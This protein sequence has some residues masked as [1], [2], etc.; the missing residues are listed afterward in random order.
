MDHISSQC[1][2]RVSAK[3]LI[4]DETREKFLVCLTNKGKWSM[5]GGGLEWG[6]G[7]QDALRRE[8]H[9]ESGLEVISMETNPAYVITSQRNDGKWTIDLIYKTILKN[10]DL[11]PTDECLELQFVSK[12]EAMQLNLFKN[13]QDFVKQ[14][15]PSNN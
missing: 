15:M 3:A 9:E 8:V 12:E 5:L 7:I 4:L 1:Y 10:I 13:V 14:F 2:Y 6:E 11:K